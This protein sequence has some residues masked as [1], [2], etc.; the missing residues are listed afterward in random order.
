M[1]GYSSTVTPL[2]LARSKICFKLSL[3][4]SRTNDFHGAKFYEEMKNEDVSNLFIDRITEEFSV[5][6]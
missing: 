6:V 4:K 2:S 5:N 1:C 3:L